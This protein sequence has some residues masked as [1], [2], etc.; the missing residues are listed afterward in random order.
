MLST[1]PTQSSFY[2]YNKYICEE[3][4]LKNQSEKG[5]YGC[6]AIEELTANQL[7]RTRSGGPGRVAYEEVYDL[8]VINWHRAI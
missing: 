6:D 1:G 2:D 5:R 3:K 8:L 7:E 4:V